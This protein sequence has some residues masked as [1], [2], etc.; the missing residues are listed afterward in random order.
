M[1]LN[2]IE[3]DQLFQL[4]QQ[5]K[6]LAEAKGIK[7]SFMPFIIK[8]GALFR[9]ASPTGLLTI[10]GVLACLLSGCFVGAEGL[11]GA[12]CNRQ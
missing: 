11:P 6:P 1:L 5:L 2:Q 3:M 9:H 4:R 7:L 10:C 8:V 12:E